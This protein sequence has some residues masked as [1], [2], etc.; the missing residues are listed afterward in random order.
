MEAWLSAG[1]IQR[2]ADLSREA[3][4]VDQAINLYVNLLGD[5]GSG[6][7]APRRRAAITSGAAELYE[8]AGEKERSLEAWVSWSYEAPDP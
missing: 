1:E 4:L 6:R 7:A 2:A 5:P 8:Q 3:G